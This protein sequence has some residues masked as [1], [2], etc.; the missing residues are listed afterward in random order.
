MDANL[1]PQYQLQIFSG[2]AWEMK[3]FDSELSYIR[4]RFEYQK[5]CQK[6]GTQIRIIG[7]RGEILDHFT[8][9]IP[10]VVK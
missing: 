5:G 3:Y 2:K 7:L 9:D 4:L 1:D 8:V 10:A 6:P